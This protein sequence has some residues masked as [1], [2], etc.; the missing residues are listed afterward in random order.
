MAIR[1]FENVIVELRAS[2]ESDAEVVHAWRFGRDVY[3]GVTVDTLGQIQV[4]QYVQNPSVSIGPAYKVFRRFREDG[5]IHLCVLCTPVAEVE[6][7]MLGILYQVES[8]A[9]QFEHNLA[10]FT[11]DLEDS[12]ADV[13]AWLDGEHEDQLEPSSKPVYPEGSFEAACMTLTV[14]DGQPDPAWD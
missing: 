11:P 3:D 4:G 9:E 13:N 8:F 1:K 14:P 6:M 2:E 10:D 12:D 7:D 5:D